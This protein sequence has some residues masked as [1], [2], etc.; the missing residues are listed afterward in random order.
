MLFRGC[1]MG[2]RDSPH[3]RRGQRVGLTALCADCY[4][5]G[6]TEAPSEMSLSRQKT[7]AAVD[8]L[9][10]TSRGGHRSARAPGSERP[11]GLLHAGR[12][13]AAHA[14]SD[15]TWMVRRLVNN[16]AI[17]EHQGRAF[18]RSVEQG[19]SAEE[20]LVGHVPDALFKM[21]CWSPVSDRTSSTLLSSEPAT[22]TSMDAVFV[23]NVKVGHDTASLIDGL[24][25]R[26][27]DPAPPPRTSPSPLPAARPWPVPRMRPV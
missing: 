16:G 6:F 26:G 17:T 3:A 4:P 24:L 23:S 15:G 25:A 7:P 9:R 21:A 19:R 8:A 10:S 5:R 1:T 14:A 20:L 13:L 2:C 11:A 12:V 22:Y 27:P 18:T